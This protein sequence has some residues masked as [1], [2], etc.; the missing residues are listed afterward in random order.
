MMDSGRDPREGF[1]FFTFLGLIVS[2]LLAVTTKHYSLV[3]NAFVL[4][5]LHPIGPVAC[6]C[7]QCDVMEV[8]LEI[9]FKVTIKVSA[10]LQFK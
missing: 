10:K 1:F 4:Y 3:I 2:W 7:L 6:G 5:T 8:S 9:S